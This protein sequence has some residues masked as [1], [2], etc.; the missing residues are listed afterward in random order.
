MGKV[1]KARDELNVTDSNGKKTLPFAEDSESI[2]KTMASGFSPL[3]NFQKRLL[4][5][6]V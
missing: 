1:L 6:T 3:F 5:Y 4:Q 2:W